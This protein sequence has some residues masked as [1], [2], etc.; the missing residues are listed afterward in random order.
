MTLPDRA[1]RL[2]RDES[3]S[4]LP[5]VLGYAMI[6]IALIIVTTA[7]TSLYI[8]QKRI[9]GVAAAAALAGSDGF[10]LTVTGDS[11]VATL[12]DEDVWTQ[13]SAIVGASTDDVVLVSARTEDG[14]TAIVDVS[15]QWH[16]P[17]VSALLPSGFTLTATATSR[18]ALDDD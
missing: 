8:T 2:S 12:S 13:A 6:A 11:A 5:L 1:R 3:G 9:D 15:I 10:T 17:L 4:I 16:P 18:T 7:V 14:V